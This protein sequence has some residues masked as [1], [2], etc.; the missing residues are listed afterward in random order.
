[1]R[2]LYRSRRERVIAGVCG[3]LAEYFN[4]DVTIVRLVW[5]VA[6]FAGGTGILAYILAVL[7]IPEEPYGHV[8]DNGPAGGATESDD[9]GRQGEPVPG[10]RGHREAGPPRGQGGAVLGWL[11]IGLGLLLLLRNL[12][13]WLTWGLFWPLILVAG[14]VYILSSALKGGRR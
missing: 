6:V 10:R 5:A 12:I 1:M 7:I 11:L 2:R 9:I 4:V 13:P 8:P 14:G 3:G